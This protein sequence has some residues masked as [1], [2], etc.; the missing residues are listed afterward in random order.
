MKRK[1]MFAPVVLDPAL[2]ER[3]I[4]VVASDPTLDRAKDVMNPAGCV[5]DHYLENPVVLASHDPTQPIGNAKPV[6]RNGRVEA[7][8]DFAQAGISA[9]ADEWC[10]LAKSGVIRA[11]SVGFDPIEFK[12]NKSGGYDYDKWELM[13]ISLVAVPANPGARIIA[14]AATLDSVEV[15]WAK[16]MPVLNAKGMYGLACL[17]QVLDDLGYLQSMT[18]LEAEMEG[19]SSSLPAMLGE[20]MR[21]LGNALIA[22]S[23][24]EVAELLAGAGAI[25]DAVAEANTAARPVSLIKALAALREKAGRALSATNADHVNEI[26]KAL[27]A[28]AG[29]H[30]AASEHVK[31][32]FEAGKK[33]QDETDVEEEDDD[34][35]LSFAA[36]QRKRLA[37]VVAIRR[38]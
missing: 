27:D 3:Q 30:A 20:A 22:M 35:E 1:Y 17:A 15:P 19:E 9:K 16:D 24:E 5:L 13:E 33:P 23:R 21:S 11:V 2:N 37:A 12:P 31:A 38:A 36:A 32:L 18:A 8:I 7:L 29:H 4:M 26:G 34:N 14:R 6:I 25:P 28:I 10:G